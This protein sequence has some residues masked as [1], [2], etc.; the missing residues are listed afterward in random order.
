MFFAC[1]DWENLRNADT[2]KQAQDIYVSKFDAEENESSEPKGC[3]H[4]AKFASK[5]GAIA[6][7]PAE[8]TVSEFPTEETPFDVD[9]IIKKVPNGNMSERVVSK[10]NQ[11]NKQLKRLNKKKAPVCNSAEVSQA[12]SSNQSED[13]AS[14]HKNSDAGSKCSL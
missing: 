13:S 2:P 5:S 8:V 9:T 10:R 12:S 11:A 3:K 6:H 1:C 4:K 14:S 7:T